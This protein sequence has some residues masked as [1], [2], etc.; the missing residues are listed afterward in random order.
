MPELLR[1]VF[2]PELSEDSFEEH[3]E[4][5]DYYDELRNYFDHRLKTDMYYNIFESIMFYC[6]VDIYHLA[7]IN[8]QINVWTIKKDKTSFGQ[9]DIDFV[10]TTITED[11]PDTW[12]EANIDAIPAKYVNR[13]SGINTSIELDPQLVGMYLEKVLTIKTQN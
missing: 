7:M 9:K 5:N 11:G 13:I 3:I 1:L 2:D 8:K 6:Y 12:M 10:C 4:L